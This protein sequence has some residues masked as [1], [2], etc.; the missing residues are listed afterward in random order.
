MTQQII[1]IGA[2][3]NDG[4]GEALRSAFNAVN[5][6][7]TEVYA[8]GPAG[9]NV[10]ISGNTISV[11]GI[12]NNLVLAGN[13]I[14]NIQANSSIMPSIDSVYDIGAPTYRINTVYADYFVGNGALLTGISGGSGNGTAIANGTSNVAVIGTNGNVSIGING[15]GN[16]ALFTSTG[17]NIKGNLVS[18]NISTAGAIIA[19]GNITGGNLVGGNIYIGNTVLTRT[20][21][22]GTRTT[23]VTVPLATNNSFNVGT[24]SGNVVVYTT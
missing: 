13:G 21:T 12:N 23:P 24:R 8:A 22:V 16:V 2:V 7:F 14:G 1:N 9:T 5:E 10:V 6:N 17:A 11:D 3:A 4:T 20:L 19:S 18:G 15:T